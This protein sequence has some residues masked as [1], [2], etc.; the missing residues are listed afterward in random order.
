MI[1]AVIARPFFTVW[2]GEDFGRE[3]PLPFYVLLLGLF[4]NL[5]CYIPWSII[6]SQGR[7]DF[8]AKFYWIQLFPYIGLTAALAY[9]FGAV[10]A[11]AAWSA[12]V[13]A[14]SYTF[15]KFAGSTAKV[16][17]TFS[18]YWW[19]LVSGTGV[20]LLPLLFALTVDN[21]SPWL[22]LLM[23]LSLII[24]SILIWRTVVA[25]DEKVWVAQLITGVYNK[26]SRAV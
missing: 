23:P 21:V 22:L 4:F 6:L 13:I 24:Y 26:I 12:R 9:N 17:F 8:F 25:P 14:E 20:L 10:G 2:A 15:F 18:S 19:P 11:A 1:L 3:S 7:T 5:C 16:H